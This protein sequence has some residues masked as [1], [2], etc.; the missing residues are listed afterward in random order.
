MEPHATREHF[1][2]AASRRVPEMF[3]PSNPFTSSH[4][5]TISTGMTRHG[6]IL[7]ALLALSVLANGCL[8]QEASSFAAEA[9]IMLPAGPFDQ[10]VLISYAQSP[11]FTN[12]VKAFASTNGWGEFEPHVL[13]PATGFLEFGV[14]SA[15][16]QMAT[17]VVSL[18]T[19]QLQAYAVSH[20][21]GEVTVVPSSS[22]GTP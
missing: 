20:K 14:Y 8:R 5:L 4:R 22:A 7:G 13:R 11:G 9:R 21:L 19:S 1:P 16:T 15:D 2:I 10:S 18:M 12:R 17:R 3:R 6:L